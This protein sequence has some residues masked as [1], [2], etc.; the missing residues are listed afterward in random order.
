MRSGMV[1]VVGGGGGLQ[2]VK[3]KGLKLFV[4]PRPSRQG[5][6][7]HAPLLKCRNFM[8]PPPPSV[9]LKLQVPMLKL[10]QN[11]LCPPFSMTRTF[12]PSLFVG[13]KLHSPYTTGIHYHFVAPLPVINDSPLVTCQYCQKTLNYRDMQHGYS[14]RWTGYIV[15]F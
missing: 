13:A 12:P 4:P 2:Y 1:V 10:P 3:I 6:N 9:W 14:L 7:C 8:H 15:I 5:K 11:C